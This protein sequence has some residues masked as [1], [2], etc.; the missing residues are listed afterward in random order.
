MSATPTR[1]RCLTGLA[2]C[3]FTALVAIAPA[4]SAAPPQHVAAGITVV[5]GAT[6]GVTRLVVPRDAKVDENPFIGSFTASGAGRVQG[7]VLR[8]AGAPVTDIRSIRAAQVNFCYSAGCTP[9]A[10]APVDRVMTVRGF[11][12]ATAVDDGHWVVPAGI[13]DLYLIADGAPGSVTLRFDGLEGTTRIRPEAPAKASIISPAP[14]TP[15]LGAG[16]IAFSAG[17]VNPVGEP[18]GLLL[19]STMIRGTG[20]AS[21]I[22]GDCFR[23][24]GPPPANNYNG[25]PGGEPQTVDPQVFPDPV[26]FKR[27][28]IM[29][30]LVRPSS[31]WTTGGYVNGFA[32]SWNVH[33][34]SVA[35]TF[36]ET[37][38]PELAD[39]PAPGDAVQQQ[40]AL[41]QRAEPAFITPPEG[42]AV[43]DAAR[44]Q[45]QQGAATDRSPCRPSMKVKRTRRSVVLSV[46]SVEMCAVEARLRS[47]KKILS[48]AAAMARPARTARLRLTLRKGRRLTVMVQTSD[49]A[50]NRARRS[51]RVR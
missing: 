8:V 4:A 10:G 39:A 42:N 50:G 36:A 47:G 17:T 3:A 34:V 21:Y 16:A 40:P 37:G 27:A 41:E 43:R 51:L 49:A 2:A 12:R 24:G 32:P 1:L 26:A 22:L 13:Y 38:P 11:A 20:P 23:P 48:R 19:E 44:E 7:L 5:E 9:E 30:A 6:S 33:H 31:T 18:G 35:L 45:P 46:R 14:A 28:S 25:C 15:Q 29:S